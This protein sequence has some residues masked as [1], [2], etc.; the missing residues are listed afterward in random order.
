MTVEDGR[1]RIVVVCRL[2]MHK[3][4]SPL[5]NL[6]A[7]VLEVDAERFQAICDGPV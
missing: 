3:L 4:T 1:I 7:V 5:V 6:E 2:C